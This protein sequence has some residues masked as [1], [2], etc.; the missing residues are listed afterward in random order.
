[1]RYP[2]GYWTKEKCQE[3]ALQCETRTIFHKKHPTGYNTSN[4]NG[5]LDEICS[6][7]EEK[8]KP[9]GYWTKE[10][11]QEEALKYKT[12]TEF[13]NYCSSAYRASLYN[14]WIDLFSH[15]TPL[16]KPKGYWTKKRCHEEA[17]KY[18]TKTEFKNNTS[19]AYSIAYNNGWLNDI[20]LH[21]EIIGNRYTRCIYVYEFKDNHAYIGLTY[22]L[23]IRNN[24]HLSKADSSVYQHIKNNCKNYNLIQ[25]TDYIPVIEA[26][27]LEEN[28][29]NQYKEKGWSILN[30]ATTG[31]IGGAYYIWTYELVKEEALKYK[32]R[33]EFLKNSC[34]AYNYAYSYNILNDICSHMEYI[35]KPNGYWTKEK[36][37]KKA[38]KYNKRSV[39]KNKSTDAYKAAHRRGW[40]DDIC[41]HMIVFY[42]ANKTKNKYWTPQEESF[43]IKNIDKGVDFCSEKLNRSET[44]VMGKWNRLKII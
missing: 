11:C 41:S 26:Q 29:V 9:D 37:H 16:Y 1:M 31:S 32:T 4:K 24:S 10:K 35:Q 40:L 15:M 21:M 38:L 22:N 33:K 36:C 8:Q 23:R 13:R 7:M 14:N 39:F 12:K 18:K 44:S 2:I 28:Y 25:L 19:S 3:L 17:L 5:W 27:K 20:C 6:H 42:N 43:L 30:K 34:G